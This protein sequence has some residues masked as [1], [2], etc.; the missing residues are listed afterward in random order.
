MNDEGGVCMSDEIKGG[1]DTIVLGKEPPPL[2]PR[3]SILSL[4]WM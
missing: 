3:D 1:G 4:P 2:P